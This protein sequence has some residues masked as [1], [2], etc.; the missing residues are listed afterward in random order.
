MEIH[1]WIEILI[2]V[3]GLLG[4]WKMLS[5]KIAAIGTKADRLDSKYFEMVADQ[6]HTLASQRPPEKTRGI[7]IDFENGTRY[8]TLLIL[9]E[10]I[11]VGTGVKLQGLYERS[12]KTVYQIQIDN[13]WRLRRHRHTEREIVEVLNGKM[14][15][16]ETGAVFEKG[17]EWDIPAGEYHAVE[18]ITTND[19]PCMIK[20]TTIP[21]LKSLEHTPLM[22]DDMEGLVGVS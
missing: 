21:A 18:F 7:D 4:V 10:W 17:A 2:T 11:Q 6:M 3:L 19:E 9:G 12:G 15:D 16:L 20:V 14:I 22:L 13:V 5:K 1:H 8:V